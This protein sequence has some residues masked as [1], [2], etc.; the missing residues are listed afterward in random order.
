MT[1]QEAIYILAQYGSNLH[2][3]NFVAQ[4]LMIAI[5]CMEKVA[6]QTEPTTEEGSMVEPRKETE[7]ERQY[8]LLWE[9]ARETYCPWK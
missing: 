5:V 8:R 2:P 4:A 9:A 1:I 3:D 6:E 7:A